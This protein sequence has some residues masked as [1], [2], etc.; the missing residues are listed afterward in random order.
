V[1]AR[2]GISARSETFTGIRLNQIGQT[3]RIIGT[4]TATTMIS[5]E[6]PS[7]R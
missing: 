7:G 6:I 4:P 2:G 5:S 3:N 1:P